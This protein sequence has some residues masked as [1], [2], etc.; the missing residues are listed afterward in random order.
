MTTIPDIR[1]ATRADRDALRA[2]QE[3]SF[4]ELGLAYYDE[5]VI[6]SFITH[7]GTMDDA[8]IDDGTFFVAVLDGLTVGC[9]GWS[10]RTPNYA[11]H[12]TEDAPV[13]ARP[14]ATVRSIF[15]H[16][17][18]ARRGIARRIM[19]R[20][21]AEIA[22]AGFE[23][24]SLGATLSGVPLYRRTGY[25]S[26]GPLVVRLPQELIFVGIRMEK[27]FAHARTGLAPAA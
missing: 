23:R 21:E 18:F 19:A 17:A 11:A 5:D 10:S 8:L 26:R 1:V 24:A 7:V 25:R 15:V 6:E 20:V 22:A 14:A 27:R 2:L 3:T 13:P 12:A 9:G 16:P 4:R